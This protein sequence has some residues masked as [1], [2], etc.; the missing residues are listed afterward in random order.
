MWKKDIKSI[1]DI[2]HANGAG[3]DITSYKHIF[4]ESKCT[5]LTFYICKN[6]G[7]VENYL[8]INELN[9]LKD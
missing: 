1:K 3:G 8:D 5:L 9:K 2:F 7:F 6:C 4:K